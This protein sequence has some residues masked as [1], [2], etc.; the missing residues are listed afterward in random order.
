ML[1]SGILM[2]LRK[3]KERVGGEIEWPM[4]S[5]TI[6]SGPDYTKAVAG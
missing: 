2:L 3:K 1:W 5:W 4:S 6:A